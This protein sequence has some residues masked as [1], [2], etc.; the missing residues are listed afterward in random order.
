MIAHIVQPR[1]E[2]IWNE[3]KEKLLIQFT[4]LSREDLVF[5]AGR[6]YQMIE[7]ISL[8]LGKSEEEMNNIIQAL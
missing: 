2:Q 4:D 3:K 1:N 8:K 5:E 6:K 7:K